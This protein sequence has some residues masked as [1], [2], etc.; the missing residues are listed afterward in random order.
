MDLQRYSRQMLVPEIGVTGQNKIRSSKVL[1][2]GAGGIGST[3]AMYLGAAGV[4][5]H[6]LDFDIVELSNLH[7]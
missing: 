7:R 5:L 4:E 2:V 1:V 6:I 3:A